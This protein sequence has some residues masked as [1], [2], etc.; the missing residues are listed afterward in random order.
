MILA[1]L[2]AT[3]A[4]DGTSLVSTEFAPTIAPSPIVTPGR[5]VALSPIHTLL[6]ITTGPFEKRGLSSGGNDI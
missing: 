5:I 6:F 3:M 4:L 1:G 2:P